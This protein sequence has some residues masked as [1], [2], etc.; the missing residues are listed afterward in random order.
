MNT[1]GINAQKEPSATGEAMY[2][3]LMPAYMGWRTMA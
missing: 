1:A 3:R 2:S